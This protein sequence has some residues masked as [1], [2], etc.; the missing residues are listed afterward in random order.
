VTPDCKAPL[1]DHWCMGAWLD[2]DAGL[3]SENDNGKA[4]FAAT[5]RDA[6]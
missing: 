3:N 6:E 4:V 1:L 5:R 2:V